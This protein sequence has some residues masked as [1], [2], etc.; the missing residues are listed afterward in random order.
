MN[1]A[2]ENVEAA[3]KA[4][5]EVDAIG[6]GARRW[7]GLRVADAAFRWPAWPGPTRI[8]TLLYRCQRCRRPWSNDGYANRKAKTRPPDWPIVLEKCL[9]V[10]DTDRR[11]LLD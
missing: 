10:R 1:G 3:L 5:D 4:L 9:V 2:N 8:A 11:A 6:A 7:N